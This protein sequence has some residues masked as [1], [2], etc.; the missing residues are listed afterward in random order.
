MYS[1]GDHCESCSKSCATCA[2]STSCLTCLNFLYLLND[3]C[4]EECPDG[5]YTYNQ[6]CLPCHPICKTCKGP[7]EDDCKSCS[8]GFQFNKNEKLC[9]SLCPNGNYFNQ[10]DNVNSLF[11]FF[12]LFLKFFF[13]RLAKCVQIIVLN[14]YIQV[15][16]VVNVSILCHWIHQHIV[17]YRVVQPIKQQ[18]I[19]VNVHHH[20]MVREDF[21]VCLKT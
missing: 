20:G 14:V 15:P 12:F 9:S 11:S 7:S 17:V 5:Y 18:M 21:F 13:F 8:K 6:Q 3:Q 2:N 10:N 4:V 1:S 19:A 16:I